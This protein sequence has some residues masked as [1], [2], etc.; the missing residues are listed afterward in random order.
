MS[1]LPAYDTLLLE[2]KGYVATLTLNRPERLNAIQPR[3]CKILP[4]VQHAP[5]SDRLRPWRTWSDQT[6]AP[7]G[8]MVMVASPYVRA[9]PHDSEL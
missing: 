9:N 8:I 6:S 4:R 3:R 2:K 7:S 1:S 5:E